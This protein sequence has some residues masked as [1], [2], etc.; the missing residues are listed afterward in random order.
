MQTA[1]TP[2]A[3]HLLWE[4]TFSGQMCYKSADVVSAHVVNGSYEKKMGLPARCAYDDRACCQNHGDIVT[5]TTIFS[6]HTNLSL[7]TVGIHVS[8][9]ALGLQYDRF[10]KQKR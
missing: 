7:R 8:Y 2:F 6:K 10:S 9:Q 4:K 3:I 1:Y 5:L